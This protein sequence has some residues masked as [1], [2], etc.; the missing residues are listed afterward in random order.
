MNNSKAESKFKLFVNEYIVHRLK[1]R[2]S[3]SG[4]R[5]ISFYTA[6]VLTVNDRFFVVDMQKNRIMFYSDGFIIYYYPETGK[7][8]TDTTYVPPREVTQ[9]L[10]KLLKQIFIKHGLEVNDT[11]YCE[12]ATSVSEKDIYRLDVLVEMGVIEGP[13]DIVENFVKK[14]AYIFDDPILG[15][16]VLVY[17]KA[18][19]SHFYKLEARFMHKDARFNINNKPA[20]IRVVV[21]ELKRV[22]HLFLHGDMEWLVYRLLFNYIKSSAKMQALI[23]KIMNNAG[24]IES[25]FYKEYKE[26]ILKLLEMGIIVRTSGGFCIVRTRTSFRVLKILNNIVPLVVSFPAIQTLTRKPELLL[27]T[28]VAYKII[29]NIVSGMQKR[30]ATAHFL[31]KLKTIYTAFMNFRNKMKRKICIILDKLKS[32]LVKLGIAVDTTNTNKQHTEAIRGAKKKA[33]AKSEAGEGGRT[34]PTITSPTIT[35]PTITSP[36]ITIYKEDAYFKRVYTLVGGRGQ[37]SLYPREFSWDLIE[38]IEEF[39]KELILTSRGQERIHIIHVRDLEL[40]IWSDEVFSAIL[41]LYLLLKGEESEEKEIRK[42]MK[43]KFLKKLKDLENSVLDTEFWK[44]VLGGERK[45]TE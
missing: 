16:I 22:L 9:T 29:D 39:E 34:S 31:K 28:F 35:S 10:H 36:T 18:K 21:N 38:R 24:F 5:D 13:Y 7:I 2:Y 27:K 23:T 19:D 17:Y 45:L 6:R 8:L 3:V 20:D 15:R 1:R 37:T 30:S 11:L 32:L 14:K 44:K 25:K 4:V 41:Y 33:K 12:V 40:D 43:G 26:E 42:W